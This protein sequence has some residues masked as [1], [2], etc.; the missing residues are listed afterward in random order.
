MLSIVNSAFTWHSRPRSEVDWDRENPF[1][2]LGG[3][4]GFLVRSGRLCGCVVSL[5]VAF[6]AAGAG[7]GSVSCKGLVCS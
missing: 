2:R 5:A 3:W 1:L 6:G 7:C 4:W